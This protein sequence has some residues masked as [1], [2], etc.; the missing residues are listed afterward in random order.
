MNHM[1]AGQ[2]EH[3]TC[4]KI[5]KKSIMHMGG[6]HSKHMMCGTLSTTSL[7]KTFIL[8]AKANGMKGSVKFF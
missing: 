8:T 5:F 2:W 7:V 6:L 3:Q 1:Q 4:C